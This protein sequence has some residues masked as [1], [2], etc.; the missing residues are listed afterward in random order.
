[1]AVAYDTLYLLTYNN[2]LNRYIT[3]YDTLTQY[4]PYVK[5]SYTDIQFN[6]A[7]GVDTKQVINAA[8]VAESYSIEEADYLLVCDAQDNIK[9]RWFIMDATWNRT[10]QYIMPLHRDVV[11]DS[12][13]P[14]VNATC[15]IEKAELTYSDPFIFNPENMTFNQIKQSETLLKDKTGVPWLVAY[16]DK[17]T[18]LKVGGP[19][20]W[21]IQVAAT[22]DLNNPDNPGWVTDMWYNISGHEYC[23]GWTDYQLNAY[24]NDYTEQ[25][26]RMLYKYSWDADG[27]RSTSYDVGVWE[28]LGSGRGYYQEDFTHVPVDF[29]GFNQSKYKQ[30][31]SVPLTLTNS[32]F[33]T[34][35]SHIEAWANTYQDQVWGLEDEQAKILNQLEGSIVKITNGDVSRYF[36][37]LPG[38]RSRLAT[39]FISGNTPVESGIRSSLEAYS[40]FDESGYSPYSTFSFSYSYDIVSLGFTELSQDTI[41]PAERL[42]GADGNYDILCMPYGDY[43]DLT[44]YAGG[45]TRHPSKT[46]LNIMQ[47]LCQA[48]S[49]AVYDV[50]LLPYCP[51]QEYIDA[52]GVLRIPSGNEVSITWGQNTYYIYNVVKA[53]STFDINFNVVSSTD[54]YTRKQNILC[55]FYRLC[56][57]NYN[58]VFEF[59]AEK[60]GGVTKIN[61]DMTLKPFQPFIHLNPDFGELY[62]TDYNDNRGL[63][64]GG[65]FSITR[66]ENEFANYELQNKNYMNVFNRE[67]ESMELNRDL[68]KQNEVLNMIAGVTGAATSGVTAGLVTSGGVGAVAGGVIGVGASLGAGIADIKNAETRFQETLDFKRDMFGY[69]LGNIKALPNSLV[70]VSIFNNINKAFPFIEYYSCTDEEKSALNNKLVWNGMSVGRIGQI[71]D[72]VRNHKTYIKAQLIHLDDKGDAHYQN[73]IADELMKGVFI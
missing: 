67:I 7:D 69:Q 15:F 6:P 13:D 3:K 41:E 22:Y 39:T 56:S 48:N 50:Q 17:T 57:P 18:S 28:P 33:L 26:D 34:S 73:V 16:V 5:A 32:G 21:D 43:G 70:N 38:I 19:E 71:K 68:D 51:L 8:T 2:Y 53:S 58:G 72:Y 27:A 44:F 45:V 40:N 9:S 31:T 12:Y 47:G 36:T 29:K 60:N 62:G 65:N 23:T 42:H 11:A 66:I 46:S 14:V 63:I 49:K 64:C 25:L 35:T 1:M 4:L 61:V 24:I 54:P 59:N 20:T 30:P 10:G 55:D 37:M 52:Q